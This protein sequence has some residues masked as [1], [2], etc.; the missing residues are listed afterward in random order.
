[1][2]PASRCEDGELGKSLSLWAG[3]PPELVRAVPYSSLCQSQAGGGGGGSGW[4]R[5]VVVVGVV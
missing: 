3:V 4:C 5:A 1:M 2:S